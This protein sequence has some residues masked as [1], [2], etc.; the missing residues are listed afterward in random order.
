MKKIYF[1]TG[2][3]TG[4]G[5]S[6]ATGLMARYL[7]SR[8]ENAATLKMVQT[9]NV[10]KSED[11]EVH[12][13][14]MGVGELT[15]DRRGW[16][17]P[18]I[19]KFPASPH[20]AAALE[21]RRVDTGAILEGVRKMQERFD[22]ILVEGAGGLAVPLTEEVL[23]GDFVR[24]QGWPVILVASDKLGSLNHTLLSL[25]FL[26]S[27]RMNFAGVVYNRF[28]RESPLIGDDTRRM[29][30]KYLTCYGF[31]PR[32]AEVGIIDMERPE[33]KEADFGVIFG[34]EK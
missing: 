31:P 16:S 29:I 12:R 22:T 32:L 2:I 6:V 4:T 33:L 14:L 8:G 1:V 26:R 28:R 34:E 13:R 27:R 21:G 11:V 3:D 23:T 7:R 17:A 10:G 25:E 18:Q 9:G 20:L 30:L 19:F 24:E 5:K 15:E